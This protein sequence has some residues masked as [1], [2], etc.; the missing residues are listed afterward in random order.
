[1]SQY[2]LPV[3][4]MEELE[5]ANSYPP[6][7][8][9]QYKFR[10]LERKQGFSKNNNPQEQLILEVQHLP[11]KTMRCYHN[12]TFNN[13]GDKGHIWLIG[14]AKK[15]LDC[16]GVEYTEEAFDRVVDR[17][18]IADFFVAEYTSKKDGKQ[19]EKFIVP[20]EG[21]LSS[22]DLNKATPSTTQIGTGAT[23]KPMEAARFDDDIPF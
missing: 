13:P 23:P 8:C 11:N 7:E 6:L 21:F 2:K 16:I 1:M 20:D 12:F 3:Y 17:E 9:G 15:F 22:D 14:K 5:S 18:G 19:K 10:V 4:T